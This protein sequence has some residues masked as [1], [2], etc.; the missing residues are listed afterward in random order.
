VLFV[1][2]SGDAMKQAA[3]EFAWIANWICLVVLFGGLVMMSR[4]IAGL[5]TAAMASWEQARNERY[6]LKSQIAIL[7][8]AL[9]VTPRDVLPHVVKIEQMLDSG[10]AVTP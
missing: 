9:Q 7:A 1:F 5:Q 6:V 8:D 3:T 2:L 4:S 10:C